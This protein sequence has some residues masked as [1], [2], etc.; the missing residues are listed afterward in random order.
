[1]MR[2]A[3]LITFTSLLSRPSI[4]A[5]HDESTPPLRGYTCKQNV[6]QPCEL[7]PEGYYCQ[8]KDVML[9]CGGNDVYCPLGSVQPTPGTQGYYTIGLEEEKTYSE[10]QCEAGFF[11]EEGVKKVCPQGYQCPTPGLSSPIECGDLSVYCEEGSVE[12]TP[13]LKGY[14][15]IGG[16]NTTRTAQVI[17]PLGY[18]ATNGLVLPCHEGH[19]GSKPGL[20]DSDSCSGTCE[21]GWYCPPA[22]ISSRQ[23]ACGG[24]NQY[25]PQGSFTPKKVQLGHYT[26]KE[27]DACRPGTYRTPD[28][29]GDVDVSSIMTSRIDGICTPCHEGTYKYLSGDDISLCLDC[30]TMAKSTPDRITCECYQSATERT[31]FKLEYNVVASKCYKLSSDEQLPPDDFYTPNS[32]LTKSEEMPCEKGHFCQGGKSECIIYVLIRMISE[33]HVSYPF[34]AYN[35]RGKV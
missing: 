13:V 25:C 12:P 6:H 9:P 35:I 20:S 5:L 8:D 19:Y 7:C 30:G 11:C 2:F 26:S 10:Q 33:S 4:K 18:Y 1:M 23:I 15:S 21:K 31:Q 16:T 28:A 22:S 34:H 27:E 24:E 14:Y 3:R 29:S 17:A 32:Q